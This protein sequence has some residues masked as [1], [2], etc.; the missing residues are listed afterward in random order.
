MRMPKVVNSVAKQDLPAK[1][2][3]L[4]IKIIA[5]NLEMDEDV[6]LPSSSCVWRGRGRCRENIINL[7]A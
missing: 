2:L 1:Q 7:T 5:N 6:E 3:F 4:V